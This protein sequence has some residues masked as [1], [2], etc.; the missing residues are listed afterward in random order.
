MHTQQFPLFLHTEKY[1]PNTVTEIAPVFSPN[2]LY[3]VQVGLLHGQTFSGTGKAAKIQLKM[4]K[5]FYRFFVRVRH[6]GG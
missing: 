1:T 4:A 3:F 6:I 2:V 5:L